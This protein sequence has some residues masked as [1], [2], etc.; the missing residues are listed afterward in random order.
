V[1]LVREGIEGKRLGTSAVL[2]LTIMTREER[3]SWESV[4]AQGR[5][6]FI[7]REGLLRRGIPFCLLLEIFCLA[8]RFFDHKPIDLETV[9]IWCPLCGSVYG[10]F[11]GT[12]VWRTGER[13]FQNEIDEDRTA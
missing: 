8:F 5:S 3:Q 13:A 12:L 2:S 6:R 9:G 10:L 11:I 1:G 4:R 7:L